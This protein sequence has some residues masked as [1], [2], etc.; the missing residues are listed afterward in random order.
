MIGGSGAQASD[1]A[2]W[3]AGGIAIALAVTTELIA[4]ALVAS[5]Q[6]ALGGAEIVAATGAAIVSIVLLALAPV[7]RGAKASLIAL[8]CA[9][10][11]A[12]IATQDPFGMRAVRRKVMAAIDK[13]EDG[14][15]REA[16]ATALAPPSGTGRV[17]IRTAA[18]SA[19][20]DFAPALTASIEAG[21]RRPETGDVRVRGAAAVD[22]SNRPPAYRVTWSIADRGASHW[23]GR[24]ATAVPSRDVALRD[25]S[26]IIVHSADRIADGAASCS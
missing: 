6:I 4:A 23:C 14:P 15:A 9:A 26:S 20:R 10:G 25:L 16:D 7:P 8:L 3:G 24:I 18:E 5:R 13:S 2:G 21:L 11:M 19:D 12:M 22:T 17:E 1:G